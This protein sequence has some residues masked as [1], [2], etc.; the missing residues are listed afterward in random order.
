MMKVK[1]KKHSNGNE[2]NQGFWK[3][4]M[5]ETGPSEKINLNVHE[6]IAGTEKTRAFCQLCRW[7]IIDRLILYRLLLID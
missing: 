7:I 1:C 4:L 3:W 2:V 5:Q 6:G